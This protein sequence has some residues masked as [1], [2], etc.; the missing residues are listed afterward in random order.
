METIIKYVVGEMRV[1]AGAL[2]TF[3]IA[4][5][6]LGTAIWWAIDWKYAAVISQQDH[7]IS[8]K[9][10]EISL[11]KGQRDEYKDKLGGSSPDQAKARLDALEKIVSQLKPRRLSPEQSNTLVG[12]LRQ[13]PS[14]KTIELTTDL[15]CSD[16]SLF[17]ADLRNV[18][19]RTGWTV[20]SDGVMGPNP[21]RLSAKGQSILIGNPQSPTADE[22]SVVEAL[23]QI[24]V[25]VDIAPIAF[26]GP[27]QMPQ[28]PHPEIGLLL[29]RPAE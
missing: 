24:A 5:L 12:L 17:A 7:V 21:S 26:T 23:K 16:C 13:I 4:L 28:M 14:K 9:D 27:P 10:S 20:I 25:P 3:V 15:S 29:S 6:V 22:R 1:I 2:A 18:F 19:E 11:L 8:N